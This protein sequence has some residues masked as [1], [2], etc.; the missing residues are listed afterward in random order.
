MATG[1]KVNGDRWEADHRTSNGRKKE[2]IEILIYGKMANVNCEYILHTMA[3]GL[4]TNF[5]A[6]STRVDM[7]LAL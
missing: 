2:N 3:Y 5:R 1:L 6:N 4:Y 7:C